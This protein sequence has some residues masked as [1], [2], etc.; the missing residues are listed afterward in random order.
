MS[1]QYQQELEVSEHSYKQAV[2]AAKILEAG[3]DSRNDVGCLQKQAP[4]IGHGIAGVETQVHEHL[5]HLTGI[6]QHGPE[7]LGRPGFNGNPW[8]DGA[9]ERIE[10]IPCK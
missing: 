1:D 4:P 10:K 7:V 5:V 3:G 6:G 2:L 9:A 8:V